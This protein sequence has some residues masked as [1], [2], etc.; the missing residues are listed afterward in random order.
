MIIQ[1][2]PGLPTDRQKLTKDTLFISGYTDHRGKVVKDYQSSEI[3]K[4][5]DYFQKEGIKSIGIA[6]KFSTRNPT[7]EKQIKDTLNG[8]FNSISLSHELSGRLNYPR[9]VRTTYLNAAVYDIYEKFITTILKA[10]KE[11]RL[12]LQF[13]Y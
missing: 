3:N 12:M 4:A 10:L 5:A 6:T 13:I 9:R 7:T 2:G 11:K 1:N 8:N